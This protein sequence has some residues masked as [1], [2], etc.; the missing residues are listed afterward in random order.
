MD[1][2]AVSTD[3]EIDRHYPYV[4]ILPRGEFARFGR[5]ADL[6]QFARAFK[7]DVKWKAE[8]ELGIE[9]NPYYRVYM[10]RDVMNITEEVKK[11]LTND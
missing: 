11:E 5:Q 7:P 8:Y 3:E 9:W 2:F 1:S 6:T 4:L 10:P